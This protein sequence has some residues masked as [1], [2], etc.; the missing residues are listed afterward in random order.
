MTN[1]AQDM[2]QVLLAL[3][4]PTCSPLFIY[5]HYRN[6]SIHVQCNSMVFDRAPASIIKWC[7]TA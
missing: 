4:V 6:L 3:T 5:F 1:R 2:S 7:M